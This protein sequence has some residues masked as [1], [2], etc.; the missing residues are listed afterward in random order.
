ML[1]LLH[2]TAHAQTRA[3]VG[4]PSLP[5]KLSWVDMA[6]HGQGPWR[7]KLGGGR[8]GPC[9][10]LSSQPPMRTLTTL[11]RAHRVTEPMRGDRSKGA[12]REANGANPVLADPLQ[13]GIVG[14]ALGADAGRRDGG[15]GGEDGEEDGGGVDWQAEDSWSGDDRDDRDEDES[16]HAAGFSTED[17]STTDADAGFEDEA[18]GLPEVRPALAYTTAY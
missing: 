3:C 4:V 10:V 6:Q 16:R 9:R 13:S 8:Q 11:R 7:A 12:R 1:F 15:G 14:A 2:N 18:L 17:F 5:R